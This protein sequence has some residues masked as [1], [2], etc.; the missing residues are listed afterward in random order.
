GNQFTAPVAVQVT[1]TDSKVGTRSLAGQKG[2]A[3][4]SQ[5]IQQGS[6]FHPAAA[7]K[8]PGAR[9]VL[10]AEDNGGISRGRHN[11]ETYSPGPQTAAGQEPGKIRNLPRPGLR[12]PKTRLLDLFVANH[13][14]EIAVVIDI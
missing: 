5:A 14:V 13:H 2:F 12:R 4:D 6:V 3:L 1:Q 9:L 7:V 8:R 10:V 11:A